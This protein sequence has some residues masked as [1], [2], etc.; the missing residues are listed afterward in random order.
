[1]AGV[2]LFFR[3]FADGYTR[4]ATMAQLVEQRIRNAWVGGSSPPGGSAKPTQIVR[5]GNLCRFFLCLFP[6]AQQICFIRYVYCIGQSCTW[7]CTCFDTTSV[8]SIF[9]S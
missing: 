6:L 4:H 8:Y 7:G 1:M 3:T 5:E 9:P 2:C